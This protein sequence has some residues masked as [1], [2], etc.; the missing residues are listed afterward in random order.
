MLGKTV[1]FFIGREGENKNRESHVD[2]QDAL[3]IKNSQALL[4]Y[5][6][7]LVPYEEPS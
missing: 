5:N 6:Y 2:S 3:L 7:V 1:F 4:V